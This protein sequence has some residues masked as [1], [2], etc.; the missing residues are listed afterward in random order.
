MARGGCDFQKKPHVRNFSA[1][2]SRARNGC[3][4]FMGAWHIWSLCKKTSM[5]IKFLILG[6]GLDLFGGGKGGGREVPILFL[7]ARGF[8]QILDRNTCRFNNVLHVRLQKFIGKHFLV[9]CR[10]LFAGKL[11]PQ[12]HRPETP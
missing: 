6:K 12:S 10:E 1:C 2:N 4:N 11:G 9:F 8:S 7:W 3:A 5:L